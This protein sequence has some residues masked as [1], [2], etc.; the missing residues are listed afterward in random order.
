MFNNNMLIIMNL[1]IIMRDIR[2]ALN[3][4]KLELNAIFYVC[5]NTCMACTIFVIC[6]VSF[7][8]HKIYIPC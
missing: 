7:D 3:Y 2:N 8:M 4:I 6:N 1:L 5:Y